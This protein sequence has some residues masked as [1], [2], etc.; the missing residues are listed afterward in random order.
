MNSSTPSKVAVGSRVRV[1][2]G[3]SSPDF[4][5]IS[6]AGWIATII[7]LSGKKPNQKFILEFDD[8]VVAAMPPDYLAR[9]EEQR[10]LYTMA[11][12]AGDQL[13]AA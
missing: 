2:E 10:L 7:E 13:E 9:C 1:K 8:R 12:L 11:C 4:P 3:V 6:F 5:D